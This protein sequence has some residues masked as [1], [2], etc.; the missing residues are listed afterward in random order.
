MN[1]NCVERSQSTVAP[2]ALHLL[3]D[4]N[5]RSLANFLARQVTYESDDELEKQIVKIYWIVLNRPP[6]PKEKRITIEA[7]KA[8]LEGLNYGSEPLTMV[9]AK[10]VHT[11]FNSAAF[12]YID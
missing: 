4:S 3:N 12:V 2:Q 1:P 8:T 6:D 9:L 11:L 7:V 10:L 5:I